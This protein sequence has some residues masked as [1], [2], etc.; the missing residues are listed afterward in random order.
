MD[1]PAVYSTSG[2]SRTIKPATRRG[3]IL[4]IQPYN[5]VT[6]K[7][8][9]QQT[10]TSSIRQSPNPRLG[11]PPRAERVVSAAFC[12]SESPRALSRIRPPLL[13]P[14]LFKPGRLLHRHVTG[15]V[16][17]INGP[18][19]QSSHRHHSMCGRIRDT[20]QMYGYTRRIAIDPGKIHHIK[21]Q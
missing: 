13:E 17:E 12:F 7:T 1:L 19:L 2:A 8:A 14:T 11:S 18:Q 5:R 20:D 15:S 10:K 6:A 4:H 9:G 21:L 16:V 3:I